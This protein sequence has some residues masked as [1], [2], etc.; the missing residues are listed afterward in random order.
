LRKKTALSGHGKAT[1]YIAISYNIK[2]EFFNILFHFLEERFMLDS[3]NNRIERA[4]EKA[5]SQVGEIQ[6]VFSIAAK[7]EMAKMVEQIA[8]TDAILSQQIVNTKQNINI[9]G[10]FAAEE[11]LVESRNLDAIL[12]GKESRA[13]TS[14][15]EE[16]G[17]TSLNGN[18]PVVDIAGVNKD[19]FSDKQTSAQVSY[20]AQSKFHDNAESTAGHQ[21][22]L[23]Q[24]KDG[25]PKY[26]DT[27]ALI[28][29]KDQIHPTDG[30]ISVREHALAKSQAS[31]VK[32]DT[33]QAKASMGVVKKN[34]DKVKF[35][36]AAGK[37]FTKAEANEIG[38]GTQKGEKIRKDFQSEYKT[39]STLKNMKQAALGAA[40]LSSLS[41]GVFNTI[42]YCQLAKQGKISEQEAVI[43]ILG[44]TV[45][46][47]A[48]SALKASAT[49][50]I[51]SLLVRYG[52]QTFTKQVSREIAKKS[53]SS[54]AR[55]NVVT[56][57]V[58]CTIDTLKDLVQL[59]LG[60]ITKEEFETRNG[61]NLLTT[62]AG[63][64][65]SA[66][67]TGLIGSLGF[68]G[69]ALIGGI[70]GGLIAGLAMQ[71]AIENHIEK[72][73]KELVQN[74]SLLLESVILLQQL[75]K[76][77]FDGQKLF[78]SFLLEDNRLEARILDIFKD[79]EYAS[80]E[81]KNN[82]DLL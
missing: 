42:T 81:M 50:G 64:A 46:S 72:P 17:K 36:D 66:I 12:K 79:I 77:I 62:A 63:L 23:A 14:R 9:K 6:P 18:D 29:P 44:E 38:A 19:I 33:V 59:H 76:R 55:T 5:F 67:G 54:I 68:T 11:V 56:L 21:A 31:K 27:D 43:K 28:G 57:G 73:Y 32:G 15:Y 52:A 58:I 60:K 53:I 69:A 16:W 49:V 71:F 45:A 13:M 26:Q 4:Y 47:A 82:I 10:G 41:S 3:E 7:V 22:G 48:D 37:G 40:A 75:T 74:T 80:Q 24:V 61:K 78:T 20:K 25:K 8:R 70:S 35:D 2:K 34:T 30:S 1:L 39:A 65:G 51:E